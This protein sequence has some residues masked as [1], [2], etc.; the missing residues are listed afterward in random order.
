LY[1]GNEGRT[2]ARVKADYDLFL[3]Q[4]LILQP[5]AE[6]N[7]YGK[8]DPHRQIGSGLSDIELSLRLRYE[9]RRELAPYLGAGWFKRF[10]GTAGLARAAG[11]GSDELELIA[12]LRVWF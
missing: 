1:V 6:A 4:R 9:V 7:L 5:Y 11:E 12:G 8:A 10:G 2:A 3:T